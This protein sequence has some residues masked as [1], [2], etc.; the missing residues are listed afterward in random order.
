MNDNVKHGIDAAAIGN[1]VATLM[2]W[3]PPLAAGL[4]VLWLAIQITE[5]VVGK[6]FSE[7]VRCAFARFRP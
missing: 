5:K 3:L 6:P 2:G 1:M 4:T 7:V